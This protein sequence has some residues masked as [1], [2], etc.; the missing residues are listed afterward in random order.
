MGTKAV[1]DGSV[2]TFDGMNVV[3]VPSSWLPSGVYF[4]IKAKGTSADPVKLTQYDVIKKSVGYSGPVVQGLVYYDAFVI[5]SKNVG[6]GVA[7]AKSA[8]LDAPSISVASHAASITAA[9]GV[10]FRYTLD[11][12]DPRYS[13]TAET[14][15]AAVT[16]AEGQTMRAVGTKDGCVGIEATKDYE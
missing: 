6:I 12:T 7:G 13:S 14:Y 9:T 10:T 11:G 16:L 3:P 2:G 1:K 5:G 15:S 4:M 8:V